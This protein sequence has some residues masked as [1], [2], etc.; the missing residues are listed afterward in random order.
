M[1]SLLFLLCVYPKCCF[2][3]LVMLT[4]YGLVKAQCVP[5]AITIGLGINQ[6]WLLNTVHPWAN[7]LTSLSLKFFVFRKG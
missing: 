7:Y 1:S 6:T 3:L 2:K 4:I 5:V